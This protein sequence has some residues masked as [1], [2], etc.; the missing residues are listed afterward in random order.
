MSNLHTFELRQREGSTG[1]ATGGNME[2]LIDGVHFPF[3]KSVKIEVDAGGFAK[4]TIEAY[5]RIKATGKVSMD[6]KKFESEDVHE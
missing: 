3:A 4:V 2:F 5:G 6:L 1:I